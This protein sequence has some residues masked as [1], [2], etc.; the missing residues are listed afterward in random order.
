MA[1]KDCRPMLSKAFEEQ[2][3]E[4]DDKGIGGKMVIYPKDGK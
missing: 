1:C 3:Y 2:G 4:V